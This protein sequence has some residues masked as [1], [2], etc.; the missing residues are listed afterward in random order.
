MKTFVI[1]NENGITVFG[2]GE[3]ALET[4]GSEK[5]ETKVELQ[6]LAAAW[7]ADRYVEIWNGI[8]G[9][10]PVKKFTDR[11]TAVTRIWN[12][13]QGL[14]GPGEQTGDVAPDVV[15][16]GKKATPVR[17]G[18]QAKHPRTTAK[19]SGKAKSAAGAR[20]GSKTAKVLALLRQSKGATLKELMKVTGW[21]EHSVRGFISGALGK[22]LGLS[23]ESTK[24]ED[25]ERLYKIDR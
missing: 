9:L 8:P 20:E 6:Q 16:K 4:Q 15:T 5:F 7:P 13:I 3:T 18:A 2:A 11:K 10:T 22:K 21:Q 14:G 12:A 1:D 24:R 23:V 25:G 19:P 17:R